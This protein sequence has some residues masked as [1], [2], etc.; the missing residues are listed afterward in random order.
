MI[1]FFVLY[2]YFD[3]VLVYINKVFV[4]GY[5]F[6]YLV[7]GLEELFSFVELFNEE[8]LLYCYV[9]GKW[10]IKE[11]LVYLMDVECV[12]I[13]C[14]MSVVCYDKMFFFGFD[15][16]VYVFVLEVNEWEF[17]GILVEYCVL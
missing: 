5:V 4:D 7:V 1:N 13:Y 3:W 15:Y 9:E 2:Q 14:V 17:S 12:F 6:D 10:I 11:I 16:N 8:K